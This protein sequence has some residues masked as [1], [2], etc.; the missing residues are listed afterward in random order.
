LVP[1]VDH[2]VLFSTQNGLV[3]IEV[4][5][6][7]WQLPKFIDINFFLFA[8]LGE[9]TVC[10]IIEA[11]VVEQLKLCMWIGAIYAALGHFG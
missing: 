3:R 10:T 9:F 6:V 7:I 1:Q 8:F 11:F 4:D 2:Q 5:I